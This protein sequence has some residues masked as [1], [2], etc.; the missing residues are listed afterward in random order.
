MKIHLIHIQLMPRQRQD[1]ERFG[2]ALAQILNTLSTNHQL[3]YATPDKHLLGYFVQ[4]EKTA[5]QIRMAID[6]NHSPNTNSKPMM[7]TGFANGDKILV[8]EL[9][10]DVSENGFNVA[11]TWLNRRSN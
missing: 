10:A 9:A 3:A 1:I 11:K 6:G 7:P 5:N 8:I 4:S 2:I